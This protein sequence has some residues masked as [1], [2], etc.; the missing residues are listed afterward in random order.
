MCKLL[1]MKILLFI[2]YDENNVFSCYFFYS[3]GLESVTHENI[4][5]FSNKLKLFF[6]WSSTPYQAN[7]Y[8]CVYLKKIKQIPITVAWF[9]CT[10]YFFLHFFIWVS[11]MFTTI[12]NILFGSCKFVRVCI[13]FLW[14]IVVFWLYVRNF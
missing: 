10:K 4:E 11:W 8:E 9:L 12:I 3:G 14:Y 13:N 5:K 2:I 7:T 1:G 6:T